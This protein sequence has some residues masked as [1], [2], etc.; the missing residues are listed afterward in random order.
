NGEIYNYKRLRNKLKVKGHSFCSDTDVEVILHLYEEYGE[1]CLKYLRGMFSFAIW[2]KKKKKL[3]LARDRIG[4]KPLYYATINSSFVFASELK[5]LM[6]YPDFKKVID[7]SA[8]S[9]YLTFGYIPSPQTIFKDIHKLEPGHYLIVKDS[10]LTKNEYWDIKPENKYSNISLV[11]DKIHKLLDEAVELRLQADVPVGSFLSGGVDSSII[12]GLAAKKMD[13]FHTFCIGFE[14][15]QYDESKYAERIADHFGTNHSTDYMGYKSLERLP[16]IL[17]HYN[18][19]YFDY[20]MIPS[21][22]VSRIAKKKVKVVLNGD[23]GDEN[24]GGYDRYVPLYKVN[25]KKK[26]LWHLNKHVNVGKVIK[27]SP[28]LLQ[29]SVLANKIK[30]NLDLFDKNSFNDYYSRLVII[31]DNDKKDIFTNKEVQSA[32]SN[33]KLKQ[34]YNKYKRIDASARKLYSDT[35]MYLPDNLCVKMDIATMANSIEARSPFLDNIFMDFTSKVSTKL[36]IS[37]DNK[38][39]ILKKAFSKD[40]PHNAMNPK[41]M[42][43]GIPLDLWMKKGLADIVKQKT[44]SKGSFVS[45]IVDKSKYQKV[46][47]HKNNFSNWKNANLAWSL[48]NLELWHSIY[49]KND[50]YKLNKIKLPKINV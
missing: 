38:K 26:A 15:K 47:S 27:K 37:G 19:P 25:P 42:G 50:E 22:F 21:F 12:T 9:N 14:E 31:Q 4:K 41:K 10:I 32:D 18:E 11:Q 23:G 43:F 5:S 45:S 13:N 49:M 29:N 1:K 40:I 46:F 2:D 34:F 20:S 7:Y 16:E 28:H 17:W 44:L 35:K 30:F 8:I 6:L 3:F 24:F 39:F 36:K 48:L 33:A